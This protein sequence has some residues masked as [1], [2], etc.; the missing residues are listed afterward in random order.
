MFN[1]MSKYPIGID[2]GSQNIYAAQLKQTRGGF[3]VRGLVHQKLEE[4]AEGTTDES[5]ALI[6]LLR[7][8]SKHERF[9]GKRAVINFSSE[10]IFSFPI[11]FQVDATE[12]ME[13]A[14]VR[15]AAEYIPFPIEEAI[16]DYPSVQNLAPDHPD[17]YKITIVAARRVFLEQYLLTLKQAGLT[18]EAVDFSVSSLI[19]LHNSLHSVPMNPIILCNIGQTQSLLSVITKESILAQQSAPWGIQ[20]VLTRILANIDLSGDQ[21]MAKILLKKYGLAYEDLKSARDGTDRTEDATIDSMRRAVYQIISPYIEELVHELHKIIG[22]VRSEQQNVTFEGIH[23]YGL[24]ALIY[25]LDHYIESRLY[26]STKLLNPM[27]EVPLSDDG[28]L[29]DISE[30]APFALALGLAMR[31]VSWL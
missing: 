22:Y 21:E 31:K 28:I 20:T 23:M 19:R 2:I 1:F 14:I 15:E 29:P 11:R 8:I 18:V 4:K 16:I 12:T 30:G 13:E 26:I 7:R 9:A 24:A 5:D 27:T 17:Y 3:A 25:H 10:N 6:P